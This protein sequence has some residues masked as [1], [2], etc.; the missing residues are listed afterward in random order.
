MKSPSKLRA[1]RYF[2]ILAFQLFSIFPLAAILDLNNNGMSDV[3][4]E[5]YNNGKLYP[6]T[7]L[8]SNDPDEDGWNNATEA[9]AGTD[10]FEPN[11]PDGI[12]VTQLEPTQTQGGYTIT[13]PTIV[14]KRYRLQASYE[15]DAWFS[16]GNSIFATGSSHSMGI[17]AVQPDSTVP[18]KI[19]WRIIV[20]D[21]D[22]DNDSLTNAEEYQLGTNPNSID[23][24]GDTLTDQAEILAATN[25]L[26]K[27]TDL[28]GINDNLDATPLLSNALAA[29]DQVGLPSSLNTDLIGNWDF[30]LMQTRT[31]I[32]AGFGPV[33]FDDLTS[34]NRDASSFGVSNNPEGMV[35]KSANHTQTFSHIDRSL[36]QG[37]GTFTVSLWAKIPAD[38]VTNNA[39]GLFTHH[40]YEPFI[41][42][43]TPNW[44]LTSATVNGI[45]LQKNGTNIVLHAGSYHYTNW[46]YNGST[47]QLRNPP[48]TSTLGVTK[49]YA[50]GKINDDQWHH[51]VM[52]RGNGVTQLYVDGV[53]QGSSNDQLYAM[54]NNS[55]T[56][57]SIGRL[58][59][60]SP[61]LG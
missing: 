56:A 47:V 24:D 58:Y 46:L 48:L 45:W 59:G 53:L 30:E 11:P 4:E 23:S 42:N 3:W 26:H 39:A 54:N 2:S 12:V 55:Y 43:G 25:P 49:T 9:V 51:I 27:D 61:S 5:Q 15:L 35:S 40:N 10:P 32:P 18:P 33:Y 50:A 22:D 21:V 52:R 29:P 36:M 44:G 28:D 60:Y 6:A 7:F 13:W 14:G 20:A 41:T 37:R 19:F 38:A 8:P 57:C 1:L 34:F 16:V 31:S 17:S